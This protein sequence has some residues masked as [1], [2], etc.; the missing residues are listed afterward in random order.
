MDEKDDENERLHLHKQTHTST[1][2]EIPGMNH[3]S[4]T[5][6]YDLEF[7]SE[8]ETTE[9]FNNVNVTTPVVS[10]R[11]ETARNLDDFTPS[12][13]FPITEESN[14]R[15]SEEV[16][17]TKLIPTDPETDLSIIISSSQ[18]VNENSDSNKKTS[19]SFDDSLSDSATEITF[20]HDHVNTF[21]STQDHS[22]SDVYST[23]TT[24]KDTNSFEIKELTFNH[25]EES[26]VSTLNDKT[27]D[28]QNVS[29]VNSNDVFQKKA[30]EAYGY[31]GGVFITGNSKYEKNHE[32]N[33]SEILN[34]TDEITTTDHEKMS[35]ILVTENTQEGNGDGIRKSS[36]YTTE[37]VGETR[38]E[39]EF[40]TTSN[41]PDGYFQ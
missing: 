40:K 12:D 29:L 35:S 27:N 20:P 25:D 8:E 16:S 34:S 7:D 3:E 38:K 18:N 4:Q 2:S 9:I 13:G 11:V 22:S 1:V 33:S 17:S 6:D 21:E 19:N 24:P 26:H 30:Y 32:N 31:L 39:I 5:P 37:L 14:S 41:I 23:F 15:A 28:I 36:D 10:Y